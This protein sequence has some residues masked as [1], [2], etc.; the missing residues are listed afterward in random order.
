M[1]SRLAR[2]VALGLILSAC[3]V[4]ADEPTT[5]TSPPETTSTVPPT[6]TIPPTTTTVDPESVVKSPVNGLPVDDPATIERRV[7]AVKIDNHPQANPH[8]GINLADMVIELRVEGITR[9]ISIWHQS[10]SEYLGPMR[11]GRPTDPTLLRAMNEPTFVISGA[12]DWVQARIVSMDVHLLGESGPPSTFRISGRNAPHNLYANT[13]EL[14]LRA[15]NNGYPDEPPEPLWNFGPMR[16]DADPASEVNID[17]SGN[18]VIW[19]WDSDSAL[20]FRTA[21]GKPSEYR[22]EDGTEGPLG[23]PVLV[24]L[25]TEQY[26]ASPPGGVAGTPLPSSE[27]TGSGI[28]FVFADGKYIEG[29]WERESDLEWFTL[30]DQDGDIIEIPPGQVWVSLVPSSRGL[31]VT[32]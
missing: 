12:Q 7:L 24:A 26:T 19:K 6:T 13:P 10:D 29:T 15:D 25:Y 14:R 2:L 1:R 16:E 18:T 31:T 9:F 20:W 4:A 32:E 8:S 30:H 3:S 21:Y 5:T 22:D 17:F 27:T 28:A 23:F 11:S